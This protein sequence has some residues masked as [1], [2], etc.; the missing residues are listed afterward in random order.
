MEPLTVMPVCEPLRPPAEA[1]I[2][3]TP[4][5]LRVALNVPWPATRDWPVGRVA[6]GSELEKVT[7]PLKSSD[8]WPK[9]STALTVNACEAPGAVGDGKPATV[10]WVAVA[11]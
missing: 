5:V 3:W 2:D 6:D 10:S 1:V 8:G 9:G 11:W 7:G 4:G